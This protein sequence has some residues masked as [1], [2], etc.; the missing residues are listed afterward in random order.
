M[1]G[2]AAGGAI[3]LLWRPEFFHGLWL[4]TIGFVLFL[5]VGGVVGRLVGGLLLR[6]RVG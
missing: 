4:G 1:I 5:V 2:A 3:A 6:R